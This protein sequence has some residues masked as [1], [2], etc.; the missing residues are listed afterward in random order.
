MDAVNYDISVDSSMVKDRAFRR[1][2]FFN[3]DPFT[4]VDGRCASSNTELDVG[5]EWVDPWN[6]FLRFRVA[7]NNAD[8]YAIKI[9]DDLPTVFLTPD[10][11]DGGISLIESIV[12]TTADGCEISRCDQLAKISKFILPLLF[13]DSYLNGIGKS[14]VL[15]RTP[16]LVQIPL[17]LLAPIFRTDKL[18]PPYLMSGLKV[19]IEWADSSAI[20]ANTTTVFE[21]LPAEDKTLVAN[22]PKPVYTISELEFN[23]E[24][25]LLHNDLSSAIHAR[26][27]SDQGIYMKTVNHTLSRSVSRAKTET[28]NVLVPVPQSFSRLVRLYA[29]VE[30]IK[31]PLVTIMSHPSTDTHMPGIKY[32]CDYNGTLI[33]HDAV[34]DSARTYFHIA[35]AHN[36][37]KLLHSGSLDEFNARFESGN[38][39]MVDLQRRV[40]SVNVPQIMVDARVEPMSSGRRVD[41]TAPLALR[42]SIPSNQID[43]AA[44][45]AG[46]KD[47][48]GGVMIYLWSEYESY[49]RLSPNGNTINI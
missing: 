6:S 42:L 11:V 48:V 3:K 8:S 37:S 10:L 2:H 19:R 35:A 4:S 26:Y 22:F 32:Q 49:I 15:E 25:V 17:P 33:P 41:G 34:D 16:G 23:F 30:T 45:N 29:S 38:F 1:H 24:H 18:L 31:S 46:I 9:V 47:Q 27:L 43:S 36:M 14:A 21:T 28:G 13:G 39:L 20:F 44:D 40:A 7:L 5:N 12:L